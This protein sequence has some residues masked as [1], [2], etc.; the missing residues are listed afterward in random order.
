MFGRTAFDAPNLVCQNEL[1][2]VSSEVTFN[3]SC[4]TASCAVDFRNC[5]G[6]L[7]AES[8]MSIPDQRPAFSKAGRCFVMFIRRMQDHS[9]NPEQACWYFPSVGPREFGPREFDSDE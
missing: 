4:Q 3:L 8:W 9:R 1:L 5:R 2:A 7:E 6:A